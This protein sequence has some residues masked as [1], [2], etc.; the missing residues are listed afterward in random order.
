MSERI[1]IEINQE[2]LGDKL[3]GLIMSYLEKCPARYCV[4]LAGHG[5]EGMKGVNYL[6]RFVI[7]QDEIAVEESICEVWRQQVKIIE[8]ER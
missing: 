6:G 4:I 5:G 3:L 2:I 8:I 1:I 7:N